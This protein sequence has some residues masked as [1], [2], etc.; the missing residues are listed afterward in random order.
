MG[1]NNLRENATEHPEWHGSVTEVLARYE[2]CEW[3]WTSV[4]RA[5]QQ[6]LVGLMMAVGLPSRGT[7]SSRHSVGALAPPPPQ[8]GGLI[9]T[10]QEMLFQHLND[11]K[12]V[13][14]DQL[15]EAAV[16]WGNNPFPIS[17]LALECKRTVRQVW[18]A[19]RD[20]LNS[21][22]FFEDWRVQLEQTVE[23]CQ[24]EAPALPASGMEYTLINSTAGAVPQDSCRNVSSLDRR[25]VV[26]YPM[27]Q[28]HHAGGV[29]PSPTGTPFLDLRAP[30]GFAITL[31]FNVLWLPPGVSLEVSEGTIGNVGREIVSLSGTD[32]PTQT[33]SSTTSTM[34]VAL[35]STGLSS[36]TPRL[37][38]LA[39]ELGCRCV[40]SGSCGP[41]GTCN[42]WFGCVCSGGFLGVRCDDASCAR[43]PSPTATSRLGRP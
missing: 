35:Q 17:C 38:A 37:I 22:G 3:T 15:G 14:C 10:S 13:C 36:G 20:L 39:A 19:C 21:S 11:M 18:F 12:G 34:H 42:S 23:L 9:C 5:M 33:I 7:F 31:S 28:E 6:L 32:K 4:R 30:P 2:Q 26:G 40:D 41:H 29:L 1:G 43:H 16:P 27:P 25:T 8:V 24:Q